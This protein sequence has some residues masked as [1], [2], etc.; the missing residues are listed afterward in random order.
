MSILTISGLGKGF[1]AQT[2][3][4]NV[5]LR[6]AR[7]EKIGIVG[8]NGGGKTTLLKMLVGRETPDR[9]TIHIARGVSIGYLSQIVDLD[10]TR[11]VRAEALTSLSTLKNAQVELRETEIALAE[12]PDEEET[13]EAYAAAVDRFDFAGGDQAEANLFGALA[14]MGFSETDLEKPITVLSG[15]EKTRLSLAKL[16]A[17]SPDVLALDEPTNHLDIRA[18][19]WLE[20]F[21][22]RFPGAVLVVSHDRRLLANVSQTIWEVEA[23]GIKTFTNGYAG[24]RE[25][26]EAARARQLAEYEQQKEEIARTEEFIRRNKAGQNTRI[27][28]G[29]Q[30]RLDRLERLERPVD[31][32]TQMKAR[33]QSSGRAGRDVVVVDQAAK[34]YGNKILLEGA[35]FSLE[36]GERVGVVGPNGV[37]KTTF[38][39]MVLGEESPDSGF[40]GRGFGVTVAYH[41]QDDDDFDG[42]LSVLDN[43]Y[44]QSGLTIAEARSH[45]AKFLFS[46]EDVY[47]P[48]SGL[49][50][51]E[52]S[53]LAMALMV[54]S[55]ANLLILDEPTNHM[56]VYSCD[57]LTDALKL[58]DGTLLL[59]SHD[60]ALLDA[61]TDKTLA[62]E[63]G[64]KV[65]LFEGNYQAYRA[66]QQAKIAAA[67]APV[68]TAKA[69]KN[70]PIP[71]ALPASRN[72]RELSK[73][74]QRAAKRVITL[75][76]TVATLET[77]LVVI[78][79]GLSAPK[80]ADD[81]LALSR[82]H[83][84]VTDEIAAKM[85]EWESATMEAEALGAPV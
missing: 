1:G 31:E 14:A 40:V 45:L 38:I 12:N 22:N 48:V 50:G 81:A 60:R 70:S 10:E 76:T 57:A 62:L 54:L 20:G 19:E 27:A 44:E 32:P 85:A 47:K 68:K 52:R 71:A 8:K 74:R 34:K 59:V 77:R 33:I 58:Y 9:G 41:K 37:G 16:L 63:G 7:G 66:E 5:S 82:E 84:Q 15:G 75:E 29:R 78:E 39:E 6:V 13:L 51:G 83:A 28:M 67:S 35:T 43:F 18:V 56:D 30:K 36:R 46:G 64:G 11:T 55:P 21:L 72:A 26:R 17:S 65:V 69:T 4:E 42:E 49:S 24:Y 79:A 80:S 61:V 53:K 2:V 73:E 23:H 25:Q 3:L